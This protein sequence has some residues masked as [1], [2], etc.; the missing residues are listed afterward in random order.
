V[1]PPAVARMI[2]KRPVPES[3]KITLPKI[4]ASDQRR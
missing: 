2:K 1:V 3:S 4:T